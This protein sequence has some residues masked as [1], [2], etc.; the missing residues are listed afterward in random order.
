MPPDAHEQWAPAQRAAGD[1]AYGPSTPTRARPAE[2]SPGPS[3]PTHVRPGD[4]GPLVVPAPE[5]TPEAE[6]RL[7]WWQRKGIVI[8]VALILM[9]AA[10]ATI[11][12]VVM[13]NESSSRQ[14]AGGP[15]DG[16]FA[17]DFGAATRPNG[18]PYDNAPGGRETWVI[19]SSCSSGACIASATRVEGTQSQASTLVLDK[20]GSTWTGVNATSGTCQGATTEYWES[21]SLQQRQDGSLAG[22]FV[23]RSTTSCARNQQVTFTRT[24]DVQ[25]GVAIANP[26]AFPP[27]VPSP[28]QGLRGRYQETDTYAVDQQSYRTSFDVATYCLRTGDRCLSVWVNPDRTNAFTF[29][30]DKWVLTTTSGDVDCKSGGTGTQQT[31]LEFP[32]PQPATDPITLLTGRGHNAVTGACPY[33]SDFDARVER[34]GD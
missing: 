5:A 32:L 7:P 27:R 4:S 19:E 13:G 2:Y 11:L 18:Q 8:P 17:V 20:I 25:S 12:T 16:T 1:N 34:T 15:L 31:S 24:G 9:I 28:A 6:R 23:V 33:S 26:Q 22:E 30:N 10:V 21:M 14:N 29:E 3:T